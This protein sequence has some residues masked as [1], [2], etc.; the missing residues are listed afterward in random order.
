[1]NTL[2]L[3][4]TED[5]STFEQLDKHLALLKRQNVLAIYHK[6]NINAS[7]ETNVEMQTYLQQAD[8]VLLLV[9]ADFLH[10]DEQFGYAQQ[11]LQ[12]NKTIVPIIARPCMWNDAKWGHIP[13]IPTQPISQYNNPN[14]GFYDTVVA[15]RKIIDPTYQPIGFEEYQK[16]YTAAIQNN[17]QQTGNNNK[18]YQEVT[19]STI[20]D[21]SQTI[22]NTNTT[23]PLP[24]ELSTYLPNTDPNKIVG[25]QTDIANLHTLLT[26]NKE[27]VLV[28]AIGG[29]GKTTLLQ[30]YVHQ[31][32][33][34]Y[35][36]LLWVTQQDN[37]DL[38]SAFIT[39]NG[40]IDNL[41][42]NTTA[43]E[44]KD[45]FD[46]ILRQLKSIEQRPKLLIIDNANNNLLHYKHQLPAQPNWHLL[47]A[48]REQIEGYKH[49]A[50]GFL[51]A[52]D[53]LGLFYTHYTRQQI[54]PKDAETLL[55]NIE[56]HTLTIELL[57]KTAQVM[58]LSANDLH[59]ALPNNAQT[60][61]NVDHQQ[62]PTAK[63]DR[64]LTYL[65]SIF[66]VSQLTP[67]QLHLLQQFACLPPDFIPYDTLSDILQTDSPT[68]QAPLPIIL[69]QLSEKGWLTTDNTADA[70]KMHPIIA[71][72]IHH[73]HPITLNNAAPL[74][75]TIT[76]KLDIDQTKDNPTH[77]FKWVDYGKALLSLFDNN[78]TP[79]ISR[80]QNNLAIVLRH[81]GDYT[82]AKTLLQK[83]VAS[84][85][86][87]FGEDHPTTAVRYNN[88]AAVLQNLGEY[89]QAKILFQKTVAANK[90]NFGEDHPT[91]ATG[92]NNLAN[93]LKDL[94]EY[95]QAKT[96]F[97]KAVASA[98]KNFGEDHPTTAVTYSNLAS[99]L[100]HLGEYAQA[101]TLFQKAVIFYEKNFGEDHPTTATCYSNLAL[102]LQDLGKYDQ[103]KELLQKAV[104]VDEKNFGEDHPSTAN[105]YSNL[106]GVLQHLGDYAEA[107]E[108]LQK[109]VASDE[110]NFGE[111]HPTTATYYNNLA[112]VLLDLGEYAQAKTLLQKAVASAEKNFG[113]DHPNTARSY[114]NL[115]I[116]LQ[117]LGDYAEA[118]TLLQKALASAEKNFG[119]DHPATAIR[120]S[121]LAM[122]LQ[123]LGDYAQAKTLFQKAVASAE[124][125]FGEDHP[126]TATC[127]SN[128]ANVLQHLS[129][130]AQAKILFQKAVALAEKNFG[131]DHP[132]TAIRYS[133]L[134]NLLQHLGDYAQAKTLLQKAV[135]SDEKNFG[136]DHPS[137][138]N[139]YNNL[140]HSYYHEGNIPHCIALKQKALAIYQKTFPN[141]HPQI[142][143][144]E[145]ELTWLRTL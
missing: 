34:H 68:T 130:Y 111:D 115:A 145:E 56:Y 45:W 36:H 84:D 64:V 121:N 12:Q 33:D 31:Y 15:L 87:N 38:G 81:F 14:Q 105:S 66:D 141:G 29:V 8:I 58:H 24:H 47:I 69:Q 35:K 144:W 48:S 30:A 113:E 57:A 103:A 51:S 122:V 123:H 43:I 39:A 97:Q 99:V 108:L 102:V 90:K 73:K 138:A 53:A 92:Y 117:Y 129:D 11:A 77:K 79:Q 80:L 28:N 135:A 134:A 7:S 3:Y 6:N 119:E 78:E 52:D 41:H 21:N 137:T 82:Q 139:R 107:K 96:L 10:S 98:E 25:R 60:Y 83:A 18:T 142:N 17:S 72:A 63:I 106:A 125:N 140:A 89:A 32:Y 70:Y 37:T 20:I 19:N 16:T 55:K 54:S 118:K 133:N 46:E 132:T 65:C 71:Q 61:I 85:E 112:N 5:Y 143:V 95:A 88:L 1:M 116:V 22:Y 136:E 40:L 110:K 127:Y 13:A 76:Q 27:V 49:Y 126:T 74:I 50:L 4:A 131:E 44:P 128:L 26:T 59:K 75:A 114:N 101:K 9:S 62:N 100:Q 94:G 91:I 67:D 23:K 2:V 109:A 124:K 86:K 42:I 93:V 104:A 120:Y